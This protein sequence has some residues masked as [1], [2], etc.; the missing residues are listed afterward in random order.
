MVLP[1]KQ[2][3]I[4][5]ARRIAANP[6]AREKAVNIAREV[7]DEAKKIARDPSPA[8]AAGRTARRYGEQLRRRF[9]PDDQDK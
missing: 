6:Q 3:L 8:R 9:L 7:S 1:L 2:L 4:Y 5:A